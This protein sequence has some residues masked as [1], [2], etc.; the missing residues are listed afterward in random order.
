MNTIKLTKAANM[1]YKL[2]AKKPAYYGVFLTPESHQKLLS[3]WN[4]AVGQPLLAKPFAHHMTIKFKP[5]EEDVAKFTPM[6]GKEIQLKVTGFAANEKGQAVKVE[7]QDIGSANANPHITISCAENVT[8]VYSNELLS[9]EFKS[10]DGPTLV[11]I[12]DAFPRT[13]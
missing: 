12:F 8:P 3:W 9:V 6:I 2:S 4:D 7:P 13:V 1:F 11:G 10:A 5:A